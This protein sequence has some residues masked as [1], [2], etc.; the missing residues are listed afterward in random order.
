MPMTWLDPEVL[1]KKL[2]RN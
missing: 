1:Y 2:E